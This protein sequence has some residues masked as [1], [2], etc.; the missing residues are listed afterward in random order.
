M[1]ENNINPEEKSLSDN[2]NFENKP[3]KH[4]S[5]GN[6]PLG[7]P[8]I[9]HENSG[10]ETDKKESF[11]ENELSDDKEST[12]NKELSDDKESIDDKKTSL[13]PSQQKIKPSNYQ[14]S[15]VDENQLKVTINTKQGV[16]IISSVKDIN[17]SVESQS[18][19]IFLY[20]KFNFNEQ[21]I[22]VFISIEDE[23]AVKSGD[24]KEIKQ[25]ELKTD[26]QK[27]SNFQINL[28]NENL[29]S[30]K[31]ETDRGIRIDSFSKEKFSL[32][33][34][35]TNKI[36]IHPKAGN[37]VQSA[38]I[39]IEIEAVNADVISKE[40]ELKLI[41]N[42]DVVDLIQP[43]SYP[44][45]AGDDDYTDLSG[46]YKN[47][48]DALRK[49]I[50]K[51]IT[52]GIVAAVAIHSAVAGLVYFNVS[53]KS[54]I[55]KPEELPRLIVIQDLPDPKINIQN[56][57]DPNKPPEIP[58]P[59]SESEKKEAIVRDLN[60]KRTVK[61]PEVKRPHREDFNT[62]K[63]T[64]SQTELERELDSLRKLVDNI[65]TLGL[66]STKIDS[67]AMTYQIPDSLRND[68]NE[69]DIGLALYFPKNWKL[70]DQREI[71]KNE[72]EFKGI[73]LTDTTAEQ[74]GTMTMFIYLDLE[75]KDY[76]PEDFKTEFP[77]FDSTITVF[78]KEPKTIAGFTEYKFYVFNKLGTEKLSIGASVR[79]QFFDQY[80]KEIESVVRSIRIKRKENLNDST[81]AGN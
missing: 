16:K 69:N 14:I 52:I 22:S 33:D 6:K 3:E 51:N 75:N 76:N 26:T 38:E 63:D 53:K 15:L 19:E 17:T 56:V 5:S 43:P 18:N 37:E 67:L 21:E 9:Q 78:S 30:I 72:T 36:Y 70:T 46:G 47:P 81:K 2:Q 4:D 48:F 79:K 60:P 66:D 1:S 12:E 45:A 29:L 25:E 44:V 71:N 8:E 49:L 54:K 27:K 13:T 20:P 64:S 10:T 73:L 80:K 68:F 61:P 74:P 77:V 50:R 34:S 58:M 65:D 24:T 40:G 39:V 55:Q 62:P 35:Q 31:I 57:E 59:E 42:P 7:N 11:A 28:I 32:K 23:S 41:P